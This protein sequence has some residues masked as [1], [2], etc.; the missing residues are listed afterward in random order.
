MGIHSLTKLISLKS[1]NSIEHVDLFS[2]KGKRVAIDT[3]IFIYK[4]LINVRYKGDYLRNKNGDIMS[5][6]YGLFNKIVTLK[7]YGITPV[8]IFDGKPPEEKQ[9]VLA[10]RNKKARESREKMKTAENKEDRD[11]YEKSSIRI[12]RQH[13]T[14]LEVLFSKMGVSY[15]HAPGEAEAYAAE[16]CRIN[17]VDAVMSEDMD[18]LVYEC[19]VLIRACIDKSNKKKDVVTKFTFDKI[20][21][22]MEMDIH[23]FIDL[24]ILC[25]CDYCSTIPK[26]GYNRAYINIKS[27][28]TIES[29]ID[30]KKFEIPDDFRDNYLLARSLFTIFRD[31]ID[32][33]ALPIVSSEYNSTVLEE[34]L[35]N[36]CNMSQSKINTAL[37][38]IEPI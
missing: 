3:S 7:S 21:E 32:I 5:H 20:K 14:D 38:K 2:F 22:D 33:N 35:S 30:S 37:K 10:Q 24:C 12:T 26:I 27:Y 8:F 23:K 34:Y 11:K 16:L 28:D 4:S 25:G 31:K 6:I 29:I 19:P 15:I 36:H 1:P 13:I 17:Y 18:T 9:F